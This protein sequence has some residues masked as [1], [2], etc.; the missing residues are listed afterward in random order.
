MKLTA[1]TR[2]RM[3]LFKVLTDPVGDRSLRAS[4]TVAI[5]AVLPADL[6]GPDR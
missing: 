2:G 1:A 3:C 6:A 4:R 5:Q